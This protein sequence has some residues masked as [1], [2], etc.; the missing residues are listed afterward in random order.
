MKKIFF[1]LFLA[2]VV[3]AIF[4]QT[5]GNI[6]DRNN[7]EARV[8]VTA[9]N[10]GDR[11]TEKEVP[12]FEDLA[13]PDEAY[14]FIFI[15]PDKT[16]Q[17]IAGF[18]GAFTDAAAETFYRLPVKRQQ[19]IL[20]AYFS[21]DDG[22]GYSLC[23]TN[24]NSCDFSSDSYAYDEVPG[25]TSLSAFNIDHDRKYRIPFIKAALE[26][27]EGPVKIL[28][29]PWSPPAWMKTNNDM[30]HGGKLRPEYRNAWAQYY[31]RFI[32]EYKK[33]GIP[34]WGITVQNEPMALQTWESCIYTG[35]EERDFV[36][37][38]LG[39]ALS[40]TE[41][42]IKLVI[43]DHNRGIMYQR[44]QAV[45][46]D[47]EAAQYVWGTGFHWYV[48]DHFENVAR[49]H[50][51]WPE[52]NL[53]FT[54]ATVASFRADRIAEWRWGEQYGESMIMDLN[55]WAAGWIDWNLLLDETGGPNHVGNLCMATMIAD[56]HAGDVQ[57]MNSY[58]YI[59]HFSKFIR[60]GA[61][62]II[63]SSDDDRFLTTAFVNPDGTIAVVVMNRTND[64][65]P[66]K[67]WMKKKATPLNSPAHSIETIVL[68]DN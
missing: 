21:M 31:I 14:P 28:A 40:A 38:Y 52:K 48:G 34:I 18:G 42:D 3:P 55:N 39:P 25:D 35:E 53:V 13:Q 37:D 8:F 12:P 61:K 66:F 41:K 2:G 5:P 4:C 65:I 20:T 57:Y 50:E 26:R 58:Y 36:R 59:G 43:W 33:E 68:S 46:D 23:R 9:K 67:L 54:E 10:T 60:P 19:A 22:I 62:R 27:A 17:T 51:A 32:G 44:A 11:L 6:R 24:I 47:P 45:L 49:V 16:F 7:I 29:S 63:S 1:F 56:T 64:D 30:L 15:D